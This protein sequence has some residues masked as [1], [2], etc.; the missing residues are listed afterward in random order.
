MQRGFDVRHDGGSALVWKGALDDG[1][2]L[3][4][5]VEQ[6]YGAQHIKLKK[7]R[8][9]RLLISPAFARW[10]VESLLICR[11]IEFWFAL[12]ACRRCAFKRQ[13]IHRRMILEFGGEG[14]S[15]GI[16]GRRLDQRKICRRQLP[17]NRNVVAVE[18]R[19]CVMCFTINQPAFNL[20][21]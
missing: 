4:A 10:L 11:I 13:I 8:V 18:T 17:L 3:A 20:I 6:V 5:H 1:F 15:G 2:D 14:F 21:G 9:R 12:I 16:I 19:A 7:R